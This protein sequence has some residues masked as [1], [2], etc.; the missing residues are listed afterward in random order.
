MERHK[1]EVLDQLFRSIEDAIKCGLES[2]DEIM[3]SLGVSLS[4]VLMIGGRNGLEKLNIFLK[5]HL[6]LFDVKPIK[7]LSASESLSKMTQCLN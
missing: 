1:K 4:L 2:D 6:I 5:S 3:K 7:K